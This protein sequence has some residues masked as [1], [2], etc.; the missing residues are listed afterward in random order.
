MTINVRQQPRWGWKNNDKLKDYHVAEVNEY[1]AGS[2]EGI[3]QRMLKSFIKD[4]KELIH[5]DIKASYATSLAN[6]DYTLLSEDI[7]H[8]KNNSNAFFLDVYNDNKAI[9]KHMTEQSY[10]RYANRVLND[11]IK[12]NI[13]KSVV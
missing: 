1:T 13:F 2:V 4:N 7:A 10:I 6:E 11:Y 5:N 9:N 8:L 12:F 3:T